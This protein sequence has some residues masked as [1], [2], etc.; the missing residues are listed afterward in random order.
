MSQVSELSSTV[1]IARVMHSQLYVRPRRRSSP[2]AHPAEEMQ[3]FK[4]FL[5]AVAEKTNPRVPSQLHVLPDVGCFQGR[6]FCSAREERCGGSNTLS[7][8]FSRDKTR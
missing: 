7:W 5:V 6:L 8:L 4:H 1:A 2:I 3:R